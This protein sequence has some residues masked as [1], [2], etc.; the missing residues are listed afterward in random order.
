MVHACSS[1]LRL[2]LLDYH[3]GAQYGVGFVR[4][5][6]LHNMCKL[7]YRQ[8]NLEELLVA[9]VAI[10]LIGLEGCQADVP[11]A[12]LV[13]QDHGEDVLFLVEDSAFLHGHT[14]EFDACR[15]HFNY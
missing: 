14:R 9:E 15:C 3:G 8:D 10:V 4:I 7:F 13:V 12:D 6:R 11:L 5:S 2:K 1:H